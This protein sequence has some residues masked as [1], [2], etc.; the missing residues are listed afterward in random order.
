L[1][2]TPK[3][4]TSMLFMVHYILFSYLIGKIE[5]QLSNGQSKA[6][7]H[8]F[9]IMDHEELKKKKQ[10]REDKKENDKKRKREEKKNKKKVS[11]LEIQSQSQLFQL[12]QEKEV[13]EEKR[14]KRRK[15]RKKNRD[16]RK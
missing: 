3:T 15:R 4:L 7:Q 11:P 13:K 9:T 16:R 12:S 6:I 14:S 2:K 1:T 5:V 8:E 10:E